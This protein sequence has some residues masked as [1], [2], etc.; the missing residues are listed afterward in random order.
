MFAAIDPSYPD[1]I[2]LRTK[3]RPV[4]DT[5]DANRVDDNGNGNAFELFAPSQTIQDQPGLVIYAS[6]NQSSY[7]RGVREDLVT[8]GHVWD[9]YSNWTHADG[10]GP[11]LIN[12][13]CPSLRSAPT[14]R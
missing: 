9:F 11:L 10:R 8:F 5:W 3:P 12:A 7:V 4:L 6:K 14:S 1:L 13:M 2:E